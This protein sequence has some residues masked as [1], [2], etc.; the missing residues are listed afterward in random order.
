MRPALF[1]NP[2]GD[3]DTPSPRGFLA[4]VFLNS[5]CWWLRSAEEGAVETLLCR[6]EVSVDMVLVVFED[7]LPL[8]A[9][10]VSPQPL[11]RYETSAK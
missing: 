8:S 2:D 4:V 10:V 5:S 1:K 3:F 7:P 9:Q 11:T 6:E